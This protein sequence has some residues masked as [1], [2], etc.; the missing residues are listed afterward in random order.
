[1]SQPHVRTNFCLVLCVICIIYDPLIFQNVCLHLR[2]VPG[3]AITG[4]IDSQRNSRIFVSEVLPDGQAFK[5]GDDS[6]KNDIKSKLNGFIPVTTCLFCALR[7][8]SGR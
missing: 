1:M 8:A 6:L 7:S 3:F 2:S 5:E 4:H